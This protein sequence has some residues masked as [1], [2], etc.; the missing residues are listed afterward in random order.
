[1]IFHYDINRIH[2]LGFGAYEADHSLKLLQSA[3]SILIVDIRASREV[4]EEHCLHRL[5]RQRRYRG[6]RRVVKRL[7]RR[8]FPAKY[9]RD[10]VSKVEDFSLLDAY[11][12]PGWIEQS[13]KEWDRFLKRVTG[14]PQGVSLIRVEAKARPNAEPGFHMSAAGGGGFW[15]VDERV[16]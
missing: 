13:Y 10:D 7:K 1:V 4:L 9:A 15:P 16:S 14:G 3:G 11:R 6:A 2:N 12:T 8:L 5:E